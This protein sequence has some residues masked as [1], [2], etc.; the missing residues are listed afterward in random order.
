MGYR[1]KRGGIGSVMWNTG[2]PLV[3]IIILQVVMFILLNFIKSIYVFSRL[4][5]AAFFRNIYY[6]FIMPADLGRLLTRPWTLITMQFSELRML[7]V[8]SNLIWMWTFGYLIQ[9]LIGNDRVAPIY[10]YSGT[11]AGVTF[12]LTANLIMPGQVQDIHYNGVVAAIM[13]LAVAATTLS[14][15]YRFFPMIGGG[16]PLWVITL[17]YFLLNV[18]AVRG[19]LYMLLPVVAAA[20]VGYW[21]MKS[22]LAGRD[23]GAWL[24]GFFDGFN[25]WMAPKR[26]RSS[27]LR[28]E[29]F[30]M[31]GDREP[32]V[33]KSNITEQRIDAILDKINQVGYD[34]LSVEEKDLLRRAGE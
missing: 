28:Q 6:W 18:A 19:N 12:L 26:K 20:A 25:R 16:I 17:I 5:E 14:P 3:M 7:S 15:K 22:L 23:P 8:I 30:Y 29:T 10:L 9:D 34:K 32:F 13:G 4:E 24:N 27:H 1:D 31:K 2:N 11:A 21:F 33:K